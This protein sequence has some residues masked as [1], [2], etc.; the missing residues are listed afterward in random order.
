M[1]KKQYIVQAV[2]THFPVR[3][4]G[5][6]GAWVKNISFKGMGDGVIG[7][8]PMFTNKRKAERF[9]RKHKIDN[10]PLEYGGDK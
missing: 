10:P 6:E 2:F 3:V 5:D 9:S 7:V 4:G 8:C 1:S